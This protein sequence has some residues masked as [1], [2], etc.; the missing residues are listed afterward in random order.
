MDNNMNN[1]TLDS[2][3]DTIKDMFNDPKLESVVTKFSDNIDDFC[4]D[5]ISK[6]PVPEPPLSF[7]D[8]MSLESSGESGGMSSFNTMV[9]ESNNNFFNSTTFKILL[10]VILLALLGLNLFKTFGDL[11]QYIIDVFGPPLR[12]FLVFLG[13]SLGEVTKQAVEVSAVGSKKGI[14]ILSD[15]VTGA[16]DLTKDVVDYTIDG[17]TELSKDSVDFTKKTVDTT[18]DTTVD[19][20]DE[21]VKNNK[22]NKEK[23]R[24]NRR[25]NLNKLPDPDDALSKTQTKNKGGFCYIGEDR[26]FRSCIKVSESDK[27]L[28]GDI[29]PTMNMC[30]NPNLRQ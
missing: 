3:I 5:S 20:F 23:H 4:M 7:K 22:N 29:Y 18:I 21:E 6:S 24:R 25:N 14:D 26:G 15:T 16:V 2:N 10:F 27:C 12:R 13:F 30:I 1:P 8:S 11:T 9:E 19:I 28:S 17:T